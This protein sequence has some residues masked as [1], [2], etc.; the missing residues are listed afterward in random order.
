[1]GRQIDG[2]S[3]V[4]RLS[5]NFID[6]PP[7]PSRVTD[8]NSCCPRRFPSFP[9]GQGH[10][11][12][13]IAKLEHSAKAL[14]RPAIVR[15]ARLHWHVRRSSTFGPMAARSMACCKSCGQKHRPSFRKE[16]EPRECGAP[17][18]IYLLG[19]L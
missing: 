14:A 11:L 13:T 12:Q 1:M 3:R 18:L 15:N 2:P 8:I 9:G 6:H 17:E 16:K 10:R 19:G 5:K 7:A 4:N